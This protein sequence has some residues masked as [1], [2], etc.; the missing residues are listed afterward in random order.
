MSP[1]LTIVVKVLDGTAYQR[2]RVGFAG[3]TG[4]G[5]GFGRGALTAFSVG[6][7]RSSVTLLTIGL[8]SRV[9]R[10]VWFRD[11]PCPP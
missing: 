2:G 3:T 4:F 6:V 1:V 9:A 8:R 11:R 5:G 10:C 7:I